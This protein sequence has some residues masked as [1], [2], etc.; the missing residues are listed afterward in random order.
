MN[1]VFIIAE[2]GVNHNGRVDLA[3]KMIDVAVQSGA[4]A[5]KFQTFKSRKE[6][7]R[8]AE[9]AEYQKE[10]T[11][12]NE[13][14]LDMAIKLELDEDAHRALFEYCQKK[15]ICFLSSP[16][17]ADSID[18][19]DRLG[20]DILKIPSGQVNNLPYLRKIGS[21]RKKLIFSTGMATLDEVKAAMDVLAA[22]GTP[23]ESITVLHCTTAYPTPFEE[24]NLTAMLTMRDR[25]GVKV[26]YSDHTLGIE[27]PIAAV[28]LGAE[29]IEKHF[30]LDKDMEGPDHRASLEPGEL[31]AM[32]TSIRNIEKAMGDGIKRV[33]IS[34]EVNISV[35]RRS[36]VAARNIKKGEVFLAEAITVKS[37][38]TGMSPMLWD[39]VIG[40]T[41]K[42]DFEEDEPI[43][44]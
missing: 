6:I 20:L 32:V 40:K 17:E 25:L 39:S 44:L 33:S 27:I 10:T 34:E 2:A 37:P 30:T 3:L 9:K 11:D 4:D 36:I 19:L 38:A 18:F 35:A 21:L 22:A 1:K 23:K 28:A 12:K 14:L 26:G 43:E 42:R 31:K 5:V 7:S 15:G 24:V 29:V 41:A 16:F 8:F 13:S